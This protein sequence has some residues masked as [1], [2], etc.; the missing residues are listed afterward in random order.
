MKDE[1]N[2]IYTM[3][4]ADPRGITQL[5]EKSF[6]EGIKQWFKI[7]NKCDYTP[8]YVMFAGTDICTFI[9]PHESLEKILKSNNFSG[10]EIINQGG[11]L[12]STVQNITYKHNFKSA[13][14]FY[15]TG[16]I[17][18]VIFDVTN[19]KILEPLI[20][21][22]NTMMSEYDLLLVANDE[23]GHRSIMY[24]YNVFVTECSSSLDIND[25]TTT[26]NFSFK[27]TKM[28]GWESYNERI[29]KKKS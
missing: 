5:H 25:T 22:N 15:V 24:F 4:S 12:I 10:V 28:F 13:T 8:E 2:L 3:G 17:K 19:A 18:C 7:K 6:I 20:K 11:K 26:E 23:Y 16:S 21:E 1:K 9:L 29:T 14:N 27:A